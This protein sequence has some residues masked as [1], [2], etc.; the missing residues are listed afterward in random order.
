MWDYA[1]TVAHSDQ[2][3]KIK[4][5]RKKLLKTIDKAKNKVSRMSDFNGDGTYRDSVVSY[6]TL[7]YRV[8]TDDFSKI[9]DMAAVAEDSYDAM[10]AY[11]KAKEIANQKLDVAGNMIDLQEH[12]FAAAHGINLTESKDL[13]G[14]KLATAGEVFKYYNKCYLI[15]FRSY[16]QEMY[17]LEALIRKDDNALQ[18]NLSALLKCATEGIRKADSLKPFKNDATLKAMCKDVLV[19]YKT[20][21]SKD[22]SILINYPV[23]KEQF[24]KLQQAYKAKAPANKTKADDTQMK[25][26]ETE[27]KKVSTEYA[28]T[29]ADLNKKRKDLLTKWDKTGS[30]FL[31]KQVPKNK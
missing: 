19:F 2:A 1:S 14:K 26:E 18:Q 8:M 4:K 3:K 23:K 27:F 30:K 10:D 7:T 31:D 15:F 24:D 12:Q 5:R 16:K 28:K 21:A 22:A 20:E 9:V 25:K 29:L 17:M 6:L 11:L 13:K